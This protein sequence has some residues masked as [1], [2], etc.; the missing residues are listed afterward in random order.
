MPPWK[1]LPRPG[2]WGHEPQNGAEKKIDGFECL[3][4]KEEG[5]RRFCC[6]IGE[7]GIG[8]AR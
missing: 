6:I 5:R 7:K 2:T 3:L 4:V 1:G 8:D